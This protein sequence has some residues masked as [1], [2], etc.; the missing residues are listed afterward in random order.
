MTEYSRMAKGF[1]TSTGGAQVVNL[2]FIPDYVE[3]NNLTAAVTPTNNGVVF[4]NW[5]KNYTATVSSTLYNPTL[6]YAVA[7]TLALQPDVV[8]TGGVTTFEAGQLL[9]FGPTLQ[10]ASITK[11]NPAVVTTATNHNLTSGQVVMLEGLYSTQYTAGMPQLSNM[12]FTVTVTGATTFTINWNTN[13]S[14]YT[15]LTGSPTGATVKQVLYPY[16]YFPGVTMISTITLG[17][18]TTITTTSAHNFRAGQQVAFRIPSQ[19]GTTQFNS[20]PNS[21]IPGQGTYGCVVAVT[22]YNTVVVNINSSAFTPFNTNQ[23]VA[24]VPGLTPPQILAVGDVNTGGETISA[25]S[26]LYPPPVT[27][28]IGTTQVGT[29]NGPGIRGAFA[30]NTAQGFIIGAGTAQTK[31]AAV[32]VGTA[33]DLIEW[34][35]FL[36]DMSVPS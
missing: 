24:S 15:A 12:P 9:Q 4:A 17:A 25:G 20:L 2:P 18:T 7:S 21:S 13:Q 1:F 26:A 34:R 16:L 35:A 28:P 22:N 5:D 11:A 14:N 19:W 10:V 32:L 8:L 36:H 6:V 27:E 30:N 29:I 33:G 23:T 3:M 31:T